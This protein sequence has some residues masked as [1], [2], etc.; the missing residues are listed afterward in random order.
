ME[1]LLVEEIGICLGRSS[2]CFRRVPPRLHPALPDT[3]LHFA[4]PIGKATLRQFLALVPGLHAHI[5]LLHFMDFIVGGQKDFLGRTGERVMPQMAVRL[6][7]HFF[8]AETGF[9]A[10]CRFIKNPFC[11]QN[12]LFRDRLFCRVQLIRRPVGAPDIFLQAGV[13]KFFLGKLQAGGRAL[14]CGRTFPDGIRFG[15][16]RFLRFMPPMCGCDMSRRGRRFLRRGEVRLGLPAADI[17]HLARGKVFLH[18]AV[19]GHL[20]G[21]LIGC[22]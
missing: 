11:F 18:R 15:L 22:F 8:K 1:R 7:L 9:P 16:R 17:C 4:F 2:F 12:L 5:F 19:M 13:R 6:L 3:G 20:L 21:D 10:A 14:P